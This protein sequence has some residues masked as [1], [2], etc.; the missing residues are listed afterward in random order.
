ME[1]N[2]RYVEGDTAA[3]TRV[4]LP[5]VIQAYR[6]VRK[7]ELNAVIVQ[8]MTGHGGFS[9][10]LNRFKCKESPSCICDPEK[11]ESILHL[12]TECPANGKE[13]VDAGMELGID[14]KTVNIQDI[15]NNNTIRKKFLNY[16][17]RIAR[18]AIKRN[19]TV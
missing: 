3:T 9:E 5:D 8:V 15:M 13:R 6:I 19:S 17:E 11:H 12:L 18:Q 7:M 4:F 1:W 2:R 16:C 10:Y 14:I